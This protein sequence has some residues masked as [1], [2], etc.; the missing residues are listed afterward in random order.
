[1]P[2]KIVLDPSKENTTDPGCLEVTEELDFLRNIN[3]SEVLFIRGRF[4]CDWALDVALARGWN[5]SRLTAPSS[6]L[7]QACPTLSEEGAK[8]FLSR[9]GELDKRIRPISLWKLSITRWPEI[10]PEGKSEVEHAWAWLLWRAKVQLDPDEQIVVTTLGDSCFPQQYP[11]LR[12]AYAV[13]DAEAAWKSI[14]EWLRCEPEAFGFPGRPEGKLPFWITARLQDEWKLKAIETRGTFFTA[15]VNAGASRDILR[16]AAAILSAYYTRN[17][18]YLTPEILTLV[19]PFQSF[20]DWIRLQDF[21]PPSDPGQPPTNLPDLFAWFSN[22]YLN[23]R[24]RNTGTAEY[25]CRIRDLGREFGLWYLRF[26]SN[27]R[28]GG[29]GR[30]IMSWSKTAKVAAEAGYVKLLIVLDGMGYIDAKQVTTF[31]ADASRRLSLDDSELVLAPL[32]TVTHFA[33]PALMAGVTPV[34][35]FEETEIGSIETRDPAVITALNQAQ[36]ADVVIWS[37]LEPDK[38]YHKPLDSQTLAFEVEARLQS[39]ARRIARIVDEVHDSKK[40]RVYITTDHGRLLSVSTRSHDV[41]IGMK[42]HGRAAWGPVSLPFD[43][44]GI[45][46][47]GELAF[48][49]AARFGLPETAAMVLSED[50]FFTADGKTGRESFTHGGVFP[51]EVL[52]P[53]LQFTRDRAPLKIIIRITG[54]GISGA[55]GRM[56]L[57]VNNTSDVRIEVMQLHLSF[58]SVPLDIKMAVSPLTRLGSDWTVASWPQKNELPAILATVICGLPTGE[59]ETYRVIPEFTVDEM[60][61][62]DTILDDL[63]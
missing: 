60:Y 13:A 18:Q 57:E 19:K 27:A 47:D 6:E 17:S 43:S 7:R 23:Y 21:L 16:S 4:L 62:R 9:F 49:D 20:Q 39:I 56:R 40:M 15:L 3:T 10:D 14:K 51:E 37:V 32:P 28:T 2:G 35:A 48:I 33:K 50:A 1:M 8:L 55:S 36:P 61:S 44:D 25:S 29:A 52:I 45:Y 59:R 53:W 24:L 11:A 30:D 41:P 42:P 63:L 22:E 31:I 54:H 38:T 58:S 26:Y 12:N 34:Q 5:Y 46:V